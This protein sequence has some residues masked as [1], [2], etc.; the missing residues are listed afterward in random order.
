MNLTAQQAREIVNQASLYNQISE[1]ASQGDTS[2]TL[3][4]MTRDIFKSLS[5]NGYRIFIE[6]ETAEMNQYNK[7]LADACDFFLISWEG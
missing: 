7:E 1:R 5:N 2:M 3:D 6:G 4:Y